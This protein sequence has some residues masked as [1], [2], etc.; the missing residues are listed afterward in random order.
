MLDK[1]DPSYFLGSIVNPLSLYFLCNHYIATE[2]IPDNK[3]YVK[4]KWNINIPYGTNNLLKNNNYN[5][6]KDFDT[7]LVQ[8]DHLEFFYNKIFPSLQKKIILFTCQYKSFSLKQSKITDEILNSS[9]ILLWISQYPIYHN[10]EKYMLFP[11][12]ID[13][14]DL[15]LYYC[16]LVGYFNDCKN[17]KEE[18]NKCYR[19][20]SRNIFNNNMKH[21]ALEQEIG[22]IHFYNK[23]SKSRY[24]INLSPNT[25]DC[26]INYEAIGLG[27]IPISN[28]LSNYKNIYGTNVC[29]KST[30]EINN[31]LKTNNIDHIYNLPNREIIL[32]SYWN[33][34]IIERIK[35]II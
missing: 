14:K 2:I 16:F 3:D 21:S 10:H 19:E 18:D 26:N 9:N 15:S 24:I 29:Y 22:N 17:H 11:V 8:T 1:I 27:C 20:K 4:Y 7:L 6:I 12:G 33:N 28:S 31:I 34:K 23:I 13:I 30:E 32:S 5:T 35:K 25:I